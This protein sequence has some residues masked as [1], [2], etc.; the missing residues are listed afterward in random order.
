MNTAAGGDAQDGPAEGRTTRYWMSGTGSS[1]LHIVCT[2]VAGSLKNPKML[3]SAGGCI[4]VLSP[5]N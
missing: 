2:H 1:I 4:T 3:H 5:Q